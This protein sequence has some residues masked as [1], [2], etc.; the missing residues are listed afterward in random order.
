MREAQA[1]LFAVGGMLHAEL[2]PVS[3]SALIDLSRE[4]LQDYLTTIVGDHEIPTSDIEWGEVNAC[5][6]WALWPSA[7]MAP[8]C[9]R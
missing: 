7:K 5:A 6:D 2:L 3:G 1:R 9:A 8:R 4:R